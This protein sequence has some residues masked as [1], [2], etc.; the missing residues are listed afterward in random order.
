MQGLTNTIVN[1][2]LAA[3]GSQAPKNVMSAIQ[4]ASAKT[5]VDFA[6]LVQQASAE[7][8]FDAGAKAKTSSAT[9]LYQFIESTWL[10]MVEK[11]G[12][13]HGISTEGKSRQQILN[14]RKDP[15][16]AAHMAAEFASENQKF[17]EDHW[18]KGQKKIGSTELYLAHFLGAGGAAAF[19]NARDENPLAKAAYIFPDAA[20]ANRNVFYDRSTGQARSFE[21]IYAFFD[22]KFQ[23][24]GE[25]SA[26]VQAGPEPAKHQDI[27]SEVLL[28]YG[29]PNSGFESVAG[30]ALREQQMMMARAFGGG[31]DQ[32][33]NI[34][35]KFMGGSPYSS[36][37]HAPIEIMLL[38]DLDLPTTPKIERHNAYL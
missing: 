8:G 3:F 26:V 15:E 16:I 6:Y 25:G 38:A 30:D 36:L 19:L 35:G 29:T 17:L 14:L 22:K 32:L 37:L 31:H 1:N 21:E 24:K 27:S 10:N 34:Y 13:K 7:S 33:S 23:I 2:V 18:A 11:H 12:Y 28:A 9:G 4:K 20:K 5:G